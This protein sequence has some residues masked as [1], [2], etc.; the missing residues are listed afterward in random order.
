MTL[1]KSEC[2][3]EHACVYTRASHVSRESDFPRKKKT[4]ISTLYLHI[5]GVYVLRVFRIFARLIARYALFAFML[6]IFALILTLVAYV[7]AR[8]S[9]R[10]LCSLSSICVQYFYETL[11]RIRI[12]FFFHLCSLAFRASISSLFGSRVGFSAWLFSS[13]FNIVQINSL[14]IN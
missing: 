13:D 3:R 4:S 7:R 11:S 5:R 12:T 10:A 6:S 8:A 14:I 2:A 9:R 1:Q